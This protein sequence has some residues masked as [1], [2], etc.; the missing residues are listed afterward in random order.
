[1]NNHHKIVGGQLYQSKE[2]DLGMLKSE[3][4]EYQSLIGFKHSI[5]NHNFPC[6]FAKKAYKK[7]SIR[8]LFCYKKED[9]YQGLIAFTNFITQSP[10]DDIYLAPLVVFFSN[11]ICENVSQFETAWMLLNWIHKQDKTPWPHN[12]STDP[13]NS[14]WAF[15]FNSVP[16]FINISSA[17]YQIL[18]SRNLGKYLCFVINP[19]SNFNYVAS[20]STRSGRLIREQIRTRV[21]LYNNYKAPEVLGFYGDEN[22]LEW[23]QYQL[24]EVGMPFPKECPFNK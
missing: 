6:L 13:N 22:N 14:N 4:F 10:Q 12:I 24:P 23:K 9:F 18:K 3:D 21:E 11:K 8:I 2:I 15:C 20:L 5:E 7:G 19:M 16:L 17:E 1:M